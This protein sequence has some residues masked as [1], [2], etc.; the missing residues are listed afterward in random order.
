MRLFGDPELQEL[1]SD[2]PLPEWLTEVASKLL[3]LP[4]DYGRFALALF[5]RR[6]GWLHHHSPGWSEEF[7][8]SALAKDEATRDAMLAGFFLNPHVFSERLYLALKPTLLALAA[9]EI[10]SQSYDSEA[11]GIFCL[12]GWLDNKPEGHRWLSSEEFRRVLVLGS[13]TF[14]THILWHVGRLDYA[15]KLCFFRGVWPRHLAVKTPP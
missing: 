14:K 13:D 12:G 15:T 10:H 8:T 1:Q 9:R 5:A 11:L 4:G 3:T 7:V 2:A 6:L